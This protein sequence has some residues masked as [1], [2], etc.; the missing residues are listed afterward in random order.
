MHKQAILYNSTSS[1]AQS[2]WDNQTYCLSVE[3]TNKMLLSY[4]EFT[5]VGLC[6]RPQR[7]K[8]NKI[9]NLNLETPGGEKTAGVS[10]S[11]GSSVEISLQREREETLDYISGINMKILI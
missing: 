11:L 10:R 5:Q 7:W 1:T 2:G 3:Q 8:E 4:S 9:T 6:S